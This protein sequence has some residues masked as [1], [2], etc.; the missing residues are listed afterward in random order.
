MLYP[1]IS[2]TK[3]SLLTRLCTMSRSTH[4]FVRQLVA[5]PIAVG[6]VGPEAAYCQINV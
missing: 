1:I 6:Y 5:S 3:V 4:Q 2:L